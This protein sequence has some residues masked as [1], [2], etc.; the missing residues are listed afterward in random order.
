MDTVYLSI[1]FILLGSILLFFELKTK[2]DEKYESFHTFFYHI[3]GVLLSIMMILVGIF[4]IFTFFSDKIIIEKQTL[5]YTYDTKNKKFNIDLL[6]TI[7]SSKKGLGG[8]YTI[9]K[10]DTIFFDAKALKNNRIILYAR[11][12]K[13]V[14]K[15]NDNRFVSE[16]KNLELRKINN[17][18]YINTKRTVIDYDIIKFL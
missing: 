16:M 15:H 9:Y 7:H 12:P 14:L 18:T 2:Y 11:L 4:Y 5:Q 10:N 13:Q 8:Y 3:R 6:F 1:S 17:S